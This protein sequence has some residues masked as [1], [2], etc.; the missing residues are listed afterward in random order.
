MPSLREHPADIATLVQ[1]FLKT[2]QRKLKRT[3][4]I[5]I[6]EVAVQSLSKYHWPGNVRELE[7]T[8]E[9]LVAKTEEGCVITA[10]QVSRELGIAPL[11]AIAAGTIE[12]IGFLQEG[13]SLDEHFDRQQL[14]IYEMVLAQV[15]GNHSQAARRLRMERTALYH[16]LERARRRLDLSDG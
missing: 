1:H 2:I 14:R 6:E 9:R 16:R 10:E 8:I 11:S 5:E 12:Y 3:G 7:N 13:E 4:P 15:G